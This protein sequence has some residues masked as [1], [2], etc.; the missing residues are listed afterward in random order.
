M[1]KNEQNWFDNYEQL[2]AYIRVHRHLPDKRKVEKRGLLNW[3]KYNRKLLRAGRL[4]D[5]RALLLN[6]LS[7]MRLPQSLPSEESTS[8]N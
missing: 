8:G 2:K 1:T 3:W 4:S 5:Q 6:E 7:E